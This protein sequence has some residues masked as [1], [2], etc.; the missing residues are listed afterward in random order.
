[1]GLYN[2]KPQFVQP[3]L[4]GTKRHTIRRRRKRPDRPGSI[5]HL[6]T[7]L[8]QPGARLLKCVTCLRVM[9][10]QINADGRIFVDEREL[11]GDEKQVLARFDGFEDLASMMAYW[12]DAGG[13]PFNGDLIVWAPD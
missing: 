10:I 8:R 13:L 9:L 2:F 3:I 4:D 11:T 7:G 12:R 5:L 1:M 6:Y